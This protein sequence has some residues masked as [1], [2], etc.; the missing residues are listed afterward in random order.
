MRAG[1]RPKPC[2]QFEMVVVL[3][4]AAGWCKV[5]SFVLLKGDV[6]HLAAVRQDTSSE[7]DLYCFHSSFMLSI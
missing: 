6:M 7:L 2:L 5:Q 1:E 3:M 4:F